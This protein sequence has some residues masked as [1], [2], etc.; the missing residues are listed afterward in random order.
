MAEKNFILTSPIRNIYPEYKNTYIYL[1]FRVKN[2]LQWSGSSILLTKIGKNTGAPIQNALKLVNNQ[3]FFQ[4]DSIHIMPI[5]YAFFGTANGI[6][7]YSDLWR[8]DISSRFFSSNPNSNSLCT[9]NL[10]ETRNGGTL[11]DYTKVIMRYETDSTGKIINTEL[12]GTTTEKIRLTFDVPTGA[13]IP[14]YF[15]EDIRMH[16]KSSNE[17]CNTVLYEDYNDFYLD[18]NKIKFIDNDKYSIT[19]SVSGQNG[20]ISPNGTIDYSSGT[21][22][23]YVITPSSA[24]YEIDQ[25]IVDNVSYLVPNRDGFTYN[26]TNIHENHTI[27]VSFAK[28]AAKKY[29]IRASYSAAPGTV[30]PQ[31]VYPIELVNNNKPLPDTQ[32]VEHGNNYTIK[33]KPIDQYEVQSV[34]TSPNIQPTVTNYNYTFRNILS[35]VNIDFKIKKLPLPTVY[36]ET[37][38]GGGIK[39]HNDQNYTTSGSE[40]LDVVPG[41]FSFDYASDANKELK[42]LKKIVNGTETNLTIY[43]KKSYS[44]YTISNI[45]EDITISAVFDDEDDPAWNGTWKLKFKITVPSNSLIIPFNILNGYTYNSSHVID[46]NEGVNTKNVLANG[47]IRKRVTPLQIMDVYDDKL[48]NLQ[49]LTPGTYMVAFNFMPDSFSIDEIYSDFIEEIYFKASDVHQGNPEYKPT[50]TFKGSSSLN[51]FAY[52]NMTSA[53]NYQVFDDNL[54]IQ[55]NGDISNGVSLNEFDNLIRQIGT[56]YIYDNKIEIP[57]FKNKRIKN[58]NNINT[59]LEILKGSVFKG[60]MLPIDT[61]NSFNKNALLFNNLGRI[62]GPVFANTSGYNQNTQSVDVTVFAAKKA[63]APFLSYNDVIKSWNA[64]VQTAT[65]IRPLGIW[66]GMQGLRCIGLNHSRYQVGCFN[67]L[68]MATDS[69]ITQYNSQYSPSIEQ[70]ISPTHYQFNNTVSPYFKLLLDNVNIEFDNTVLNVSD[71]SLITNKVVLYLPNSVYIDSSQVRF[72]NGWQWYTKINGSY[73]WTTWKLILPIETYG[74]QYK[75]WYTGI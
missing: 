26:F 13:E 14:T 72:N 73:T 53:P 54:L 45:K 56:D 28:K 38:L 27:I 9:Y 16:V 18:D 60:A 17:A 19:A 71:Y 25:V 37:T 70:G 41:S 66:E 63:W 61:Y 40:Q 43:N 59:K 20:S 55:G 47:V 5:D 52:V 22:A 49:F 11:N 39:K 74:T 51:K 29:T 31:D 46:C 44:N 42:S 48:F 62:E 3:W 6:T 50:L 8:S 23:S 24:D 64:G 57:T 2:V 32:Q 65:A 33:V 36:W 34:Q 68:R 10:L 30:I 35:D 58:W 15:L 7:L 4:N 21:T 69:E 12:D 75:D 1:T 67:G